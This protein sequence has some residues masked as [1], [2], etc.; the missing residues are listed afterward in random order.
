MSPLFYLGVLTEDV[1]GSPH[2]PGASPVQGA[3]RPWG[4]ANIPSPPSALFSFRTRW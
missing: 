1:S 3:D 2:R 4:P